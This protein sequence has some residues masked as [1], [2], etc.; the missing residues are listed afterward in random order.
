MITDREPEKGLL[1]LKIIWSAMLMS[2][3]IYLFVGLQITA[4][5]QPMEEAA[6]SVLKTVLYIV[7]LTILM[8]TRLLRKRLLS[9]NG[10]NRL[11]AQ[12]A[13]P[14]ALQIY[15]IAT[16]LALALSEAIGIFGFVL[17]ILGK[18][19]LDLYLLLV[20][21]AAMFMYRPNRDDLIALSRK[22][23]EGSTPGGATG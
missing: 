23:R 12:A 3:A 7:A 19:P 4:N 18:N 10:Q 13:R 6:F 9:G 20:S 22:M 17:Y 15:S 8:V 1:T 14:P 11:P 2:L 5:V 21:A 16:V